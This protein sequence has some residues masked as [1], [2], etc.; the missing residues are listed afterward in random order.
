[1][2]DATPIESRPQ[3]VIEDTRR[4]PFLTG[5]VAARG[6]A[7]KN[8]FRC[9]RDHCVAQRFA[10]QRRPGVDTGRLLAEWPAPMAPFSRQ[11]HQIRHDR[12]ACSRD[13]GLILLRTIG[14]AR[15]QPIRQAGT[16]PELLEEARD[17][18]PPL[19]ATCRTFDAQH[20]ELA[21]RTADRSIAGHFSRT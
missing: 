2:P 9:E 7:Y 1:L 10:G 5:R 17:V 8:V 14:G 11:I 3:G 20:V 15:V 12:P 19:P 13:T 4:H 16:G 18:I 21:D 6:R